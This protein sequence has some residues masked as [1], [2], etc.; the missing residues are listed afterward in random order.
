LLGSLSPS[1]MGQATFL[2]TFCWITL[3]SLIQGQLRHLGG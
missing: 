1:H 2:V 3:C